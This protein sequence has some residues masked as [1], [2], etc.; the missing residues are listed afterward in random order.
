MQNRLDELARELGSLLLERNSAVVTVESCTGGFI[1]E[2][3]TR[4]P[5]SSA[6]FERGFVTYS[7]SAKQDLV[8][9]R[10]DSLLRN[11]AVSRVVAREM[12]IGGIQASCADIAVSVTGIAGPD[13]GTDDKPVGTVWI[14][15]AHRTGQVAEQKFLFPGDRQQVRAASVE[16]ALLEAIEFIKDCDRS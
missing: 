6:W 8:G 5:G 4:I 7:N 9:V 3:L 14:A 16:S 12:A 11:G 13:G 1:A 15:W 2:V 10:E